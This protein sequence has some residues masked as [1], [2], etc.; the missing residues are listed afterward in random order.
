MPTNRPCLAGDPPFRTKARRPAAGHRSNRAT[1]GAGDKV[2][3]PAFVHLRNKWR[4]APCVCRGR[5][6]PPRGPRLGE[7]ARGLLGSALQKPRI[8]RCSFAHQTGGIF[9]MLSASRKPPKVASGTAKKIR[10]SVQF[11]RPTQ[12]TTP[13]FCNVGVDSGPCPAHN[14]RSGLYCAIRGGGSDG[15]PRRSQSRR[16]NNGSID[17]MCDSN[18]D[19]YRFC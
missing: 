7:S 9:A 13:N 8:V 1:H 15:K 6:R 14:P 17:L 11:R 10:F 3:P 18:H 2:T 16:K 4:G 5:P 12:I 19:D